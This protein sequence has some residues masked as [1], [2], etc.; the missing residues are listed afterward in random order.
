MGYSHVKSQSPQTQLASLPFSN[1]K[2]PGATFGVFGITVDAFTAHADVDLGAGWTGALILTAGRNKT[3]RFAPP[4]LGE[5]RVKGRDRSM[6]ARLE[7]NGSLTRIAIGTYLQDGNTD[8]HIDVRQ[9][10]GVGNF[11]QRR[12]S[13]GVFGEIERKFG[14]VTAS[15]ALR[16]QYDRQRRTGGFAPEFPGLALDFD[17]RTTALLPRASISWAVTPNWRVGAL[18]QQA[19]APGG[20]FL[21]LTLDSE[22]QFQKERL[23]DLEL[24]VRGSFD[25]GRGSF[26]LNAFHY[27][28]KDQQRSFPRAVR[29]PGVPVFVLA[30][31]TNVPKS[32]SRGLEANLRWAPNS[33]VSFSG[34]VGLLDTKILKGDGN[35]GIE[36]GNKLARS[37]MLSGNAAIEWSFSEG[38]FASLRLGGRTGY[39]SD[40]ANMPSRRVKGHWTIDTRLE[41]T[42]GGARLFVYG[43]NLLNKFGINSYFNE[44]AAELAHPR[45]FGIGIDLSF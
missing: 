21:P 24:F 11:K 7:R 41:K 32:V 31:V 25:G 37:P 5:A 28:M 20:G 44:V 16:L 9:L 23:T 39:F 35:P 18:L 2:N 36:K 19:T 38:W 10:V 30:E 33:E 4:S 29:I 8:Q 12:T 27:W 13:L 43:R 14:D 22:G 40:D 45:H 6:E 1:R 42:I 34:A 26:N 3:R 17:I 15:G